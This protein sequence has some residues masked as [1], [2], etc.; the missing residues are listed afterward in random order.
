MGREGIMTLFCEIA[1]SGENKETKVRTNR[2]AVHAFDH[3]TWP[4]NQT[5]LT[6]TGKSL[7][8]ASDV[9]N[10]SLSPFGIINN[11]SYHKIHY[12]KPPPTPSP[13]K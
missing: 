12:N 4:R 13:P 6:L 5:H 2:L 1:G 7:G 9:N 8:Q 3:E 11:V 10:T